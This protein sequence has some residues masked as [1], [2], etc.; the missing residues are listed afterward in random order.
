[1]RD[2]QEIRDALAS[3]IILFAGFESK[4]TMAARACAERIRVLEWALSEPTDPMP[5]EPPAPGSGNGAA[6]LPPDGGP[7]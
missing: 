1:M 4:G 5:S 7:E 2:E 3:E 6:D